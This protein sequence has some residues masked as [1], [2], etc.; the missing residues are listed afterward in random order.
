MMKFQ[1]HISKFGLFASAIGGIVGSGWLLGPL[2]AAQYAGPAAIISWLIGGLLM[3]VIALT[4]AE[5]ATMFPMAGSMVRFTHLSHGPFVSFVMAWVSWLAALIVAPIETMAL[6]QYASNYVPHLFDKVNGEA[7]LSITGMLIAAAIMLTM[8]FLNMLGI[9]WVA[10]TN[11]AIVCWKLA[12]P[13]CT[14]VLLFIF[15][16]HPANFTHFGGFMPMGLHGVLAAL[17]AA[18][19]IFSFIGYSPSIQLAGEAK[20]PQRAVPIAILGSISLCIILYVLLQVVFTGAVSANSISNGWHHINFS[21]DAGP[22]AGIMTA[23]GIAWFVKIL[24][25][26]AMISPFGTAFIYTC[27]T[28]RMNY[29][30]SENQYA[31]KAFL[32]LNRKG[33]PVAAVMVNFFIGLIFILPFPSWQKM[34]S[35]IVSIFVFAYAIGPIALLS[36]RRQQPKIARPFKVP[37][38]NFTCLLAFYICNLILFWTGWE[39]IFRMIIT[40]SIGLIYFAVYAIRSKHVLHLK[41]G[42]WLFPYIVGLGAISYLGS[43]G[44]GMGILPFGWDF[45]VIAIFSAI[46]FRFAINQNGSDHD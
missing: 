33:V 24:Y 35:F 37:F 9:K 44:G 8:C 23:I 25:F 22:F 15:S 41:N 39:T 19:V 38:A 30:A 21:G 28:A 11:S 5:L 26:D 46:C 43:Y 4:F 18:G 7:V 34:V 1:R 10:K 29:A 27:A 6:L 16:F 3:M 20:N 45:A 42:L 32:N 17:P 36:L 13:L 40:I 12:V 2:Y 14:I 31:P